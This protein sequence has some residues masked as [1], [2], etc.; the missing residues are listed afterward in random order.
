MKGKRS[1]VT[2]GSVVMVLAVAGLMAGA[3]DAQQNVLDFDGASWVE[4]G[5]FASDFGID[6]DAPKTVEGWA[7]TR[8]FDGNATLWSMGNRADGQE[9]FAATRG[10]VDGW[11]FAYYGMPGQ[12][13]HPSEERWVHFAQV[14]TGTEAIT[15]ADGEEMVRNSYDLDTGDD[16]P[17]RIGGGW[18][19]REPDES[20]NGMMADVRV[21]DHARSQSEIEANMTQRLTG[22]ESGL[23]GY[24]PMNDGEGGTV[25]DLSPT[26]ND[27]SFDGPGTAEWV[28]TDDL[29]VTGHAAIEVAPDPR[30]F[31]APEGSTEFG[32]VQLHEDYEEEATF[33]WYF[34]D[35]ELEGETGDG[36]FI[37]ET[38]VEQAGTYTVVVNHPDF[39]IPQE[40]DI[41]LRVEEVQAPA[42][43]VLGL[44][45]L[46]LALAGSAAYG[47]RGKHR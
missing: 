24:W 42:A 46:T 23:V 8:V 32:P 37:D 6:G 36:F 16:E 26:G 27:G 33:Q 7:Y 4:T 21:W 45:M 5:V 2:R 9:W 41:E 18:A 43:G 38:T 12:F 1:G 13:D 10:D 34:E 28:E 40:F 17:F 3:A 14:Y 44:G 31:V 25:Q 39:E 19:A 11:N 15:Y 29:P 22:D 30:V 47:I 20:F 35:E